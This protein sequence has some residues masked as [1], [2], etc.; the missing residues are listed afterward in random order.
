MLGSK[1]LA[2][3]CQ[4]FRAA[5]MVSCISV[6]VV[7]AYGQL[8]T[9]T[10]NG[11]I[12]DTS[13]AV[14][15]GAVVVLHSVDTNVERR[16]KTNTAGAYAFLNLNPGTYTL[17]ASDKGFNTKSLA[18]FTLTVNQTATLDVALDVGTVGQTVEVHANAVAVQTSTAEL[19]VVIAKKAVV[20]LPLNG[21][22]FTQLLT[23][24][25]GASPVS[26]AQNSGGFLAAPIG[27]FSFPAMNGQ[28]N[29]SN[30]FL[31][32]GIN[33]FSSIVSTYM[34]PPIIDDV[35][36]FKVESHNDQA[37]F[38]QVVGGIVN[39]VTKSGTNQL[40]GD[41]WEFLRNNAFDARN[42]FLP[43][44]AP[45]RQNQFGITAGGPV[46]LPKLYN[47]HNKTFFFLAYQGFLLR[48]PADHYYRVP[49]TANLQGDLSD[50]PTQIYDPFSTRE[51]PNRPGQFIRDQ[52]PG[53]RIPNSLIDPGMALYA[54]TVLPAP[55][56]TDVADRNALDVT[57][58]RQDEHD[59]SARIDHVQGEKNFF[60]F[61]YSGTLQ[62]VSS[63]G[64]MQS[65]A[66]RL[67]FRATNWGGSWVH[68]FGPTSILQ[69]QIGRAYGRYDTFS[70]FRTSVVSN[71]AAF[72]KQIGFSD[73]FASNFRSGQTYVP[74][75]NVADFFSG[76]E[77][78]GLQTPGETLQEQANYTKIIGDHTLKFGGGVSSMTFRNLQQNP[79]VSFAATQTADPENLAATGS[80]LASFLLGV[81]DSAV[82]RNVGDTMGW[83]GV[84]SGYF[85]DQW[86]ATPKLTV[87]LGLRYDRT[88]I[89]SYGT[90]AAG[91]QY[92][93]DLDLLRG[94]YI[95]QHAVGSLPPCSQKGFAPCIPTPT[96]ELPP[97]V[98]LSSTNK[99][100]HDTTLNFQP[101]VGLAYRLFPK[102]AIRAGFG[103]F[104]DN[105]A[106]VTQM[107]RNIEGSWPSIDE[108]FNGNL[109]YPTTAAPT[110]TL[111]AEDPI[112][113]AGLLPPPTP[114][115]SNNYFFDPFI[116][117]PYSL[118]W[119]FGFETEI[120]NATILSVNYVGSGDRRLDIGGYYNTA[121]TPG[122][123]DPQSRAPFPYSIPANFDRSW[124]RSNYN[125]LQV[126]LN[127]QYRNGLAYLLSYTWSKSID[128]GC[129]GWF[130]VEGCSIQDPH[131]FNNDRGVSAFD[132][133]HV[134]TLNWIYQLP[135]G[136][137]KRLQTGSKIL[138]YVLG[139]WQLNGILT[140]HSG[141]P[142]NVNISGDIANT[143]NLSGYMRPN[144][145]GDPTLS[146]PTPQEWFDIAAFAAPPL[147]T[148]GNFGR[149]VLRADWVHNVD[150]S[151]FRNFP[152]GESR[153]FALRFE[154]FNA[155]N[156]PNFAIP[157]SNMSSTTFGKVLATANSPRQL[158]LSLKFVF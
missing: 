152:I 142:Y 87:N 52:F 20:D 69:V 78:E 88:V 17:Q 146:N 148:F 2:K 109:N 102:T 86:K 138:D 120:A 55:I 134:L 10:I 27:E 155:F 16:T 136:T 156:T 98:V 77:N 95:V 121:L 65:L 110:P 82:R 79:S 13:G 40:H 43:S 39:V 67:E 84:I 127:R 158:Q 118:Q 94:I 37:E 92:V 32:D 93:G 26:V 33:N 147:Y 62:N 157:S 53:N 144:L 137:G 22:N 59:Y 150:L 99:L 3:P 113:G 66:S 35:Q 143:G 107:A 145:I 5:V 31:L 154:A 135:I 111:R 131:H 129:S 54:K 101:R 9:A 96:G 42:F 41:M 34:V 140:L 56:A 100:L 72:A 83:G 139:N 133:T 115:T 29:R 14:I 117:N 47:G 58:Y 112:A 97:H 8:S 30:M 70:N 44:V 116:K 71:S 4:L 6:A 128:I 151:V 63:S 49:T 46:V 125:A 61:R 91:N 12:R 103:V 23:L 141:Q 68:T 132:L 104:F 48:H 60:W 149:D 36:E 124:G 25:P 130:G 18:P 108:Q 75:L 106:G 126:T 80:S 15:A 24:T 81:P 51:D 74:A 50:I 28:T 122:P 64:G 89:P 21:R 119:N 105:W 153:Y 123:G 76:G 1:A 114:F 11:T 85:Q 45:F 57:P 90:A 19:G 7:P 38:G 73:D